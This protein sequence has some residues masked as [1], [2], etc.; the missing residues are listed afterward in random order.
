VPAAR[1]APAAAGTL[2]AVLA[3]P[4]DESLACGGT[5]AR[6][7]D[8]GV[9]VVVFSA[10]IGERGGPT[11]PVRDDALARVR[12]DEIRAAARTL[13]VAEVILMDHPDGELRWE[14]VPELHAQIV[15]AVRRFAPSAVITFGADGL[16]WHPD[17]IGVYERTVT[18]LGTF[19]PAAPP[20]Y[21]V[22][23]PRGTMPA[24]VDAARSRGW[25]PPPKGLWSLVPGAF[26][27]HAAPPT[28]VVDV[29]P[30][31]GRKL[32]A[33]RCHG[34]QMGDDH[35]FDRLDAEEARRWLGLEHFHRGA[36]ET[37]PGLLEAL[38]ADPSVASAASSAAP[39][40]RRPEQAAAPARPSTRTPS[41]E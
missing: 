18:A 41:C 22:T 5:L 38:L 16:Y 27:L 32:A 13:G 10:T 7:A 19:G 30:W 36:G 31:V 11:G 15:A 1:T 34:S 28:L 39:G 25:T 33:L 26:G 6:L 37:R 29:R 23:M 3:H 20:L 35:P 17:H 2:L 12:R 8:A 40:A 4:D 9:R 24:I 14:R 21:H